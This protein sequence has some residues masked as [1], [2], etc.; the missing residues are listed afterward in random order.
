MLPVIRGLGTAVI[1]ALSAIYMYYPEQHWIP[2][3]IAV[4][5]SLGIHIIPAVTQTK[6]EKP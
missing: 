4:A 3:T 6:E 2:V 5:G 1:T